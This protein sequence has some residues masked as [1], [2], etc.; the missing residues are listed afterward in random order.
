MNNWKC[1]FG[2]H[3]FEVYKEF[4]YTDIRGNV[5]GKKIV[6]RCSNCGKLKV[7]TVNTIANI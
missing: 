3:S 4:D 6:S 1:L 2:L 7:T 5:I